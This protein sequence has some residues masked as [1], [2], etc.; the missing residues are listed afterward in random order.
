ML[1]RWPSTDRS[2]SKARHLLL[3]YLEAWNLVGVADSAQLV[4]SELVT[5]AVRHAHVPGRLI[6]TRYERLA[7]GVR[8]EVHDADDAKP[9][10]QTPT[11]DA[12]S[13]RGLTLVDA[14]TAGHWGV[15][16]RVGVG[17][18]VWAVCTDDDN[19]ARTS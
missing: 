12:E 2:V 18:L 11:L 13:G 4:L 7:N 10:L 8:I 1:K 5:N 15:S 16:A 19:R 17:K 6:E 14:L 3:R 9:Q